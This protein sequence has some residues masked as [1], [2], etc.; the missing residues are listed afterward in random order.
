MQMYEPKNGWLTT[1]GD[2]LFTVA[3]LQASGTHAGLTRPLEVHLD[4]W[5]RVEAD[6]MRAA[7]GL[8]RA[9]ARVAWAQSALGDALVRFAATLLLG[10]GQNRAHPT[11]VRF[12]P[13]P[14]NE[15]ARLGLDRQLSA[16][17]KFGT[18]SEEVTLP[19]A[20]ATELKA[21][22]VAMEHGHATV[23]VREEASGEV[24]RVSVRQAQWREEANTLR[25]KTEVALG[26]Y[27][28]DHKLPRVYPARFFQGRKA[29]RKSATKKAAK[30]TSK[31]ATVQPAAPT[32]TAPA[33]P[34]T[35]QPVTTVEAP[36]GVGA[37]RVLALPDDILRGLAE[38]FVAA[39]P[40]NVQTVVRSRRTG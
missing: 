6:R 9:Y 30:P 13:R 1:R 33:K 27:A 11:Y 14:V 25:R 22:F 4:G 2:L 39:L 29:S 20:A 31:T 17:E 8:T 16:L 15:T 32:Q 21:V 12:F 19:D 24:T 23:T 10:C 26:D 40:A 5:T 35:T 38:E 7:D 3:T 36:A 28:A 37:D 34:V 18:L